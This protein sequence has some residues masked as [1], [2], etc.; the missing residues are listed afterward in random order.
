MSTYSNNYG[1][2]GILQGRVTG[3]RQELGWEKLV[4]AFYDSAHHTY[5]GTLCVMCTLIHMSLKSELCLVAEG[6]PVVHVAPEPLGDV[7]VEL[8]VDAPGEGSRAPE[9]KVIPPRLIFLLL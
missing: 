5:L 6:G 7:Q 9:T 8:L 3:V 4:A 1:V 2:S